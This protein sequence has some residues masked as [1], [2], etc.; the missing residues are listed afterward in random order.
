MRL[1]YGNPVAQQILREVEAYARQHP[2]RLDII[3]V[4]N[5]EPSRIY[6]NRKLQQASK[7]GMQA[8]LHHL[9][10]TTS[11]SDLLAL[12]DQLNA[13]SAVTGMIVQLPLPGPLEQEMI[14]ERIHPLKD[15]DGLHPYNIGLLALGRARWAPATPW[16]IVELLKYYSIVTEGKHVVVVGRGRLVGTPL[17][18][19]LSRAAP[20]GNATT[21]LCHTRT[22]DLYE[23]TQKADIVVVAAGQPR[24]FPPEGLKPGAIVIDV[25]IHRVEGQIVGD[26]HPEVAQ[27]ASALTPVPGGVGPLTVAALLQNVCKAHQAQTLAQ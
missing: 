14:L 16:G 9:P 19:L 20:Y 18:L 1:L 15:V 25:G 8:V 10:E 12:I 2:L 22:S 3:L 13:D 7:V 23:H 17:A 5:H 4:G 26:T 11:A 24:W 6:V 27:A 21:T